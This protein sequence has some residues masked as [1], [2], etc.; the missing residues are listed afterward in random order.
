[1]NIEIANKT[2]TIPP[3]RIERLEAAFAEPRYAATQLEAGRQF[4]ISEKL[5]DLIAELQKHSSLEEI[6]RRLSIRWRQSLTSADLYS[7]IIKIIVPR[8]L[9]YAANEGQPKQAMRA[10]TGLRRRLLSGQFR[11]NFINAGLVE[12]VCSPLTV[13]YEPLL[14]M[15][16]LVL[17]AASRWLLYSTVDWDFYK[18][19]VADVPPTEYL[20][21][22]G[23]LLGVVLFHELGHSSAQIKNGLH[24][25]PIGFQLYFYIPALYADVDASWSLKPGRRLVID[26]GGVYF[27]AIAASILYILY[28]ETGSI[29]LLTV[30]LMSDTLCVLTLNPFIKFDGYWLLGD[31]LSIPNLDRVSGLV[32]RD[33]WNR[34]RQR[35][36]GTP[37]GLLPAG[38]LRGAVT[39]S[40][41]VLRQVFFFGLTA[42]TLWNA[43]LL[44]TRAWSAFS[45]FAA[46]LVRGMQ[47]FDVVVVFAS[48]LRLA[49]FALLVMTI[50]LLIVSAAIRVWRSIQGI[51]GAFVRSRPEGALP[52]AATVAEG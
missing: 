50:T 42:L 52:G 40:Y 28:L 38:W 32:L 15:L 14:V 3:I 46:S 6:A 18:Q 36:A 8:G 51:Q 21:S 10:K 19:V 13:F 43:P 35:P 9:A 29:A 12:R 24:A 30:V 23:L 27:Q 39:L 16:G 5:A 7:I 48:V 34:L 47:R 4:M 11:W 44:Y 26:I 33:R 20:V 41:A 22:I 17:I 31:A 49:L 25:G 1:M 45:V 37:T 2:F